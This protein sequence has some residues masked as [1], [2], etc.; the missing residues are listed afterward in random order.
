[1]ARKT[2]RLSTPKGDDASS[3]GEAGSPLWTTKAGLHYGFDF[4]TGSAIFANGAVISTEFLEEEARRDQVVYGRVIAM[5][6]VDFATVQASFNKRLQAF[7]QRQKIKAQRPRSSSRAIPGSTSATG[8]S[9]DRHAGRRSPGSEALRTTEHFARK[10]RAAA[11]CSR[12]QSCRSPPLHELIGRNMRTGNVHSSVPS[13]D[14]AST[15]EDTEQ[16]STPSTVPTLPHSQDTTSDVRSAKQVAVRT[17]WTS[18]QMAL[19]EQR[20]GNGAK[21]F[22]TVQVT[23]VNRVAEATSWARGARRS[24]RLRI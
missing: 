12:T 24:E 4:T 1:M 15:I 3:E 19:Y 11:S 2:G 9:M 14:T 18:G 17:Q 16:M 20:T 13:P 21:R 8:K 22:V 5:D 10:C 6:S 7:E 23:T